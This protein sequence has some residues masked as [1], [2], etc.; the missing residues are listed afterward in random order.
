MC[1]AVA[2]LLLPALHNG[3]P[4]LSQDTAT[5]L[6][7]GKQGF[8]PADRP[9]YY[10][11]FIRH[12]SMVTT[13][14]FPVIVQAL[15]VYALIFLTVKKWIILP[16]KHLGMTAA[17]ITLVLSVT[18][19]LAVFTSMLIP[20]LFAGLGVLA[21]MLFLSSENNRWEQLFLIVLILFA[22]AVHLSHVPL[23]V[24]TAV[25][26]ALMQTGKS[27][28]LR[29]FIRSAVL[30]SSIVLIIPVF[31]FLLF[32]KFVLSE[33]GYVFLTARLS[34]SGILRDYQDK[35]P[36]MLL[37]ELRRE[38]NQASLSAV[39]FLWDEDSPVYQNCPAPAKRTE[40][41][42]GYTCFRYKN[43]IYKQVVKQ[44]IRDPAVFRSLVSAS[45]LSWKDQLTSFRMNDLVLPFSKRN[46]QSE[47]YKMISFIYPSELHQFE[48]SVQYNRENDY[49][50]LNCI[51]LWS[52]IGGSVFLIASLCWVNSF[53][54]ITLV[55]LLAVVANAAI[56]GCLSDV[57]D[58]YEARVLWIVPLLALINGFEF[59]RQLNKPLLVPAP[60]I[61]PPSQ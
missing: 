40:N 28:R 31:N 49:R 34:Q 15:C 53:R 32:Q 58:R 12:I 27:S 60:I 4:L 42:P 45:L 56:C 36:A 23:L 14:W 25:L 1:I 3:Y 37:P 17:L 54:R 16:S 51:F 46:P 61:L 19:S 59:I 52:V 11:L 26:C 39:N 29:L 8:L 18:T 21:V 9:Y 55:V 43:G 22:A 7:S 5:H 30:V 33:S 41:E 13:L 10:G 38:K 2:A 57:S 20:D 44:V 6:Y 35:H 48:T 24:F 47:L 50:V